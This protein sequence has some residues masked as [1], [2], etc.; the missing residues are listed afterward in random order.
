MGYAVELYFDRQTERKIAALR[1]VLEEHGI[2]LMLGKSGDRPHLSLAGFSNVDRAALISLVQEYA[3]GMEQFSVQ[4]SAIGTFPTAENVLFL[5]P[6]PTLQLLNYHQEFHQR[7][8][9]SKLIS[10]P[11]YAPANWVPHCSIEMNIPGEKFAGAIELC[12]Q[13]FK[14]MQG[15]FEAIGVIEFWPVKQLATWPL[16]APPANRS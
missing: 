8:I 5:S 7:L 2:P 11:Y 14:P 16:A 15:Q 1:H 13:A 3:N 12:S 6:V 9:K 4:L 10:S